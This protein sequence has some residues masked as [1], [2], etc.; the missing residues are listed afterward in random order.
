MADKDVRKTYV[1]SRSL[2]RELLECTADT[3]EEWWLFKVT[4]ISSSGMR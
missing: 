4:A 2:F 1:D 3:N